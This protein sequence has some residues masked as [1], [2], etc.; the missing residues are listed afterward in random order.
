[1]NNLLQKFSTA[2]D[3]HLNVKLFLAKVILNS[4]EVCVIKE[5]SMHSV[6]VN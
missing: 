3:C 5:M 6:E 1:M 4:E 2:D